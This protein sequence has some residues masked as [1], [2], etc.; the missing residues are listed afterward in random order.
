MRPKTFLREFE[1]RAML[2][3]DRAYRVAQER[4]TYRL[5]N[6]KPTTMKQIVPKKPH[7]A[8]IKTKKVL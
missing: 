4:E 8:V 2:V 5:N 6:K 1:V 3:T 7:N